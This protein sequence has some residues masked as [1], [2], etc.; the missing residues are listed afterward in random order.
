MT[1]ATRSTLFGHKQESKKIRGGD[2]DSSMIAEE[3]GKSQRSK[4]PTSS[5][6]KAPSPNLGGKWLRSLDHF[7]TDR[8]RGTKREN[9][10]TYSLKHILI[11][12]LGGKRGHAGRLNLEGWGVV[13]PASRCG[14]SSIPTLL[15]D[16]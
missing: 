9:V 5:C 14:D 8:V 4:R 15:G 3:K 11:R 16:R 7:G 1:R 2:T 13:I 12:L 6:R 10:F